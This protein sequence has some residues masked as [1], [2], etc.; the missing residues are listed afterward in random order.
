MTLEPAVFIRTLIFVLS[1]EIAV[2]YFIWY[3]RVRRVH[4]AEPM[5][6]L[7]I[8]IAI[9][10]LGTAVSVG[11]SVSA[12][13]LFHAAIW[14]SLP[15]QLSGAGYTIGTLCC[16]IPCW[17]ISCR[18]GTRQIVWN[19]VLRMLVALGLASAVCAVTLHGGIPGAQ[20]MVSSPGPY[21][22]VKL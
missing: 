21:V 8:G 12:I 7:M 20:S 22:A 16:L 10:Q 19:V 3:L 13:L 14:S 6:E 9:A 5:R 4:P 18:A 11:H 17:R 15:Q 1:A 2:R